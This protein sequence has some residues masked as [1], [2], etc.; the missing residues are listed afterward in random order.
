DVGDQL[1]LV[2]TGAT[3]VGTVN[4]HNAYNVTGSQIQLLVAGDVTVVQPSFVTV[5]FTSNAGGDASY[6]R[7][8]VVTWST[9]F[10][11][12]VIVDTSGGTPTMLLDVGGVPRAAQYVSGS[13]TSTLVFSYTVGPNDMDPNGISVPA[14]R[15]LLNGGTITTVGGGAVDLDV[16]PLADN[17]A[18]QVN[19]T[20]AVNLSALAAGSPRGFVI[21]GQTTSDTSGWSV[22]SAGDVNGDGYADVIVGAPSAD[23]TGGNDAGRSY[24]IFGGSAMV[25]I[26]LSSLTAG[27]STQGFVINGQTTT[28]NSGISVSNAG[29]VNGDGLADL[30]VGASQSDPPGA[31]NGG[32]S[33]VVFGKTDGG[34]L[35]LSSLTAG[36]ST[37]GFAINGQ[38]NG[39]LSGRSVSGAGDV[40]GDG[41][42]DL[43]VGAYSAD[44]APS[45]MT[46]SGRSYVVF[47]KT[48]GAVVN[49]SSLTSGVSS[50]GFI[51][52]GQA[53]SDL[54][55][56]SV[57]GA[58]DVNGDGL[59]D[60]IVSGHQSDTATGVDAGRAYVVFGKTGTAVVDLSA[61]AAGGNT[62][63]FVING[64]SVSDYSGWSVSNA[65]DV[66]GDGLADVVIGAYQADPP[67]AFN[68]GRSF[69]VFG[70]TGTDVVDLSSFTNG[71][72]TQGFLING[73]SGGDRSG[74][75]VSYAGDINGD[76]LA[77][78]IVGAYLSDPAAGTDAGRAYVVYGKTGSGIVELS[79]LAASNNSQGFVINGQAGSD[80]AGYSVSGAGDINGDGFDDLI[81]GA[82]QSDLPGAVDAGRSYVIYGGAQYVSSAV[83]AQVGIVG[84]ANTLTGT[85][86][87]DTLIGRALAD[88]LVG[89]GGADAFYGGAGAD[90]LVLNASNVASLNLAGAHVDGGSGI[91]TLSLANTGGVG[92][93]LDL[94]AIGN[95]KLVG[96]ERFDITG[97]ANN[98]L[99]LNVAELL[100]LPDSE[101]Q[102][103]FNAFSSWGGVAANTGRIQVVVDGDAGDNVVLT[104]LP[105]WSVA[106]TVTNEGVTYTAYNHLTSHTQILIDQAVTTAVI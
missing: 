20:N 74:N 41:L 99:T 3:L 15:L 4:G 18:Q 98:T 31:S 21:N 64:Y 34:V 103:G 52:N 22:S 57:S 26:D 106:G 16:T 6:D 102:S 71:A 24:V 44:A 8:E 86:A 97:T 19:T 96:I 35:N 28:D 39:D 94:T 2:G 100:A 92:I 73:Q 62:Q 101:G 13:G 79:T 68:A 14:G 67:G 89:G 5:A 83:A 105:N 55:G 76:G 29:D 88:T 53:A 81:V 43:I 90:T 56:W 33:Y 61:I 51:I 40:N 72:S 48:S 78:M 91:D 30:I 37:Q 27:T 65:G 70:K 17:A 58:G 49:L 32:R 50:E 42:A 77:D 11:Q 84:V 60:V 95:T 63:G 7:N 1:R 47:G 80:N 9:T 36:S 54:S 59:A 45:G 66:N 25:S 69:V 12:P 82:M 38:T 46:D 87:A 10:A 104:D 85:A 93:T 75:S 23:P